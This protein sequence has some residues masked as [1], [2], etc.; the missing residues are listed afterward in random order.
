MSVYHHRHKR[1]KKHI[2]VNVRQ[3]KLSFLQYET[4][5]NKDQLKETH[6]ILTKVRAP[7]RLKLLGHDFGKIHG[8]YLETKNIIHPK[9]EKTYGEWSDY[10]GNLIAHQSNLVDINEIFRPVD[11]GYHE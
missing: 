8:G 7:P 10:V 1:Q 2:G 9:G 5:L 6:K 4:F 3:D 11:E